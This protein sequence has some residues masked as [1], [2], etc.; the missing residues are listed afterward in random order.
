MLC[1]R[2]FKQPFVIINGHLKLQTVLPELQTPW[3]R[4]GSGFFIPF[5]LPAVFNTLSFLF[6]FQYPRTNRLCAAKKTKTNGK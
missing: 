1:I 5:D 2:N 3:P 6:I 4:S